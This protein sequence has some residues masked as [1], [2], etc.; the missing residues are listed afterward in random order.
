[1]PEANRTNA[2]KSVPAAA[3][4][5][6][7][8]TGMDTVPA[9]ALALDSDEDV[10]LDALVT[11]QHR[12]DP[13]MPEAGTT[14]SQR[15]TTGIEKLPQPPNSSIRRVVAVVSGKGGV[16][17][18]SVASLIATEIARRGLSVALL[19]ADITG[20]SIPKMLGVTGTPTTIEKQLVPEKSRSGIRVMS[21]NLLVEREDEP[22]IWRGPLIAGAVKQFWSD[23][24]W[25]EVDYMIVDLPPGTGDVPLTVLQS[26]PVD[27]V[28]IVSTPQDLSAM[29]V[30]K[31]VNMVKM[32]NVPV[33]GLVENMGWLICPKCGERLEPFGPGKAE[34]MATEMGIDY[35]GSLPLDPLVSELGDRGRVEE[36]KPETLTTIVSLL[37]GKVRLN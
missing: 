15:Q 13:H 37:L 21:L 10:D 30:K 29:V 4:A 18:S 19:D 12:S 35:L 27:S 1:M 3:P 2:W 24:L 33:A 36:Y 22:V 26:L 8:D 17:K 34:K 14:G 23:V 32:M 5:G 11:E 6:V 25:G 7:M 16:G 20:P 28:V 31:A 9:G